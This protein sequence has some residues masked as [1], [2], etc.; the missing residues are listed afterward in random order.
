MNSRHFVIGDIHG[1]ARA[2]DAIL[3]AIAPTGADC[4]TFLGDYID[5]G[6][7]SKAVLD[8]LIR[9]G[10]IA[11]PLIRPIAGNHEALLLAALNDRDA[12]REWLRYGGEQTLASFGVAKISEIPNHY[13]EWLAALPLY[14]ED[15]N[16]VFVHAGAN[17]NRPMNR[18]TENDLLWRH[19]PSPVYMANGKALYCGHTPRT[20]PVISPLFV[21]LDTGIA[22]G[23]LLSCYEI[24]TGQLMQANRWGEISE[25]TQAVAA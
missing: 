7:D 16:A 22:N 15:D 1:H 24:T 14:I 17:P 21:N 3:N 25:T 19:L 11:R 20:A 4:I 18:Q 5:H 12:E 9:L 13:V 10:N 2:L 6:P 8:T 23:G